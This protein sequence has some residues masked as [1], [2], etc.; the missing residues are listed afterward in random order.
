MRPFDL[1]QPTSVEETV[2]LL[3]QH[4]DDA[5]LIG[6]G[7]MLMILLR[8]RLI[9]PR[10]LV[11]TLDIAGLGGISANGEG[12]TFGATALISFTSSPST[13]PL[14]PI[15]SAVYCSQ[16]PGAAPISSTRLPSAS[17]WYLRSIS[18]SL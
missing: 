9:D 10:Y 14:G 11:S 1:L 16:L 17:K 2:G 4:G 3:G 12:M 6:G 13:N 8:E 5:R 7:A 18:I 15:F